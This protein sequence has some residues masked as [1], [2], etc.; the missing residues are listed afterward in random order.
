MKIKKT[1]GEVEQFEE[2]K[3]YDSIRNAGVEHS[4]AEEVLR[5]VTHDANNLQSTNHV[6]YATQQALLHHKDIAGAARYNLKHAISKLGPTGY[7]F[8]KFIARLFE[9]YGYTTKTNQVL[10][11]KCVT[12]EIDVLASRKEGDMM[13]HYMVECK[14]H[15]YQGAKTNIRVALYTHARFQDIVNNWCKDTECPV[16]Q[17]TAWIV[18]NTRVTKQAIQ[19]AECVGMR[20]LAWHYPKRASLNSMVESQHLYPVT[21]IPNMAN[22]IRKQLLNNDIVVLED[23]LEPTEKQLVKATGIA[24]EIITGLRET[25]KTILG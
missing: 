18:T 16:G 7:P 14:H 13:K 8:E 2:E 6:H 1:D 10:Q 12:H 4:L 5:M 21:V 9:R 15:H 25:A 22:D 24:P 23:L 11:G 17:H 20:V 3:L 19:Y